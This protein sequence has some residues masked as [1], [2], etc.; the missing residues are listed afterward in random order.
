MDPLACRK[1][2]TRYVETFC[3]I[4][5]KHQIYVNFANWLLICIHLVVVVVRLYGVRMACVLPLPA[6]P[7]KHTTFPEIQTAVRGN[8]FQPV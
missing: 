8:N 3:I 4:W 6:H 1:V 5:G 2:S 7:L